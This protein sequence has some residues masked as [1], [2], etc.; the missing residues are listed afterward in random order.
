MKKEIIIISIIITFTFFIVLFSIYEMQKI[1]RQ[2]IKA[3]PEEKGQIYQP[4][5]KL[6]PSRPQDYGMIVIDE[7][8]RPQTQEDWD[9]LLG[10]KIRALKSELPSE[11]KEKIREQIKEDSQVT[12]DKIK[13]IDEGI[14]KCQDILKDEPNNQ[15]AK[16]RL[17]R[18][19]MLK[20]IAKELPD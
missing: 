7:Y 3:I 5:P 9:N 14:V 15:E 2:V 10:A 18:L 11:A 4:A 17:E 16:E 1:K 8:N 13:Q 20:S 19:M 6:V 12:Q